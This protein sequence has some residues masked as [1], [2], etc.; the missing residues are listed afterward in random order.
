MGDLGSNA[1]VGFLHPENEVSARG[2]CER[3]NVLE[4][5]PSVSIAISIGSPLIV[6]GDPLRDAGFCKRSEVSFGDL[7]NVNSVDGHYSDISR[8]VIDV[9]SGIGQPRRRALRSG[10]QLLD[11]GAEG[12]CKRFF[13]FS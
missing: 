2:V 9:G 10:A 13:S 4:K 12:W 3:R 5:F 7:I 1:F 11:R 8:L 6:H